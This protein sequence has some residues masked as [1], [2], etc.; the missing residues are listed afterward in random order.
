M[1]TVI[2]DPVFGKMTYQH[3]WYKTDDIV[4]FGK[5]WDITIAAQAYTGQSILQIQRE[6]YKWYTQHRDEVAEKITKALIQ[7]INI[8]CEALADAWV[9]ARKVN[10]PSELD[11]IVSPKTLLLSRND[12]IVMLFE[13]KWDVDHG[14]A[15]QI[16]PHYEI[17][18]QDL[19]L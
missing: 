13:C 12:S 9:G 1:A 19:F 18:P 11:G 17:G 10:F 4:L 7:Y 16:Y 15:V 6:N 3:R 14:L 5:H 8:N 2:N